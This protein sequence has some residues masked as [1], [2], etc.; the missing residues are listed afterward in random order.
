M[1][2][3][4]QLQADEISLFAK[5]GAVCDVYDAITSNRPYKA[6]WEP[7][8]S[9]Q[10]M[11]QWEGHFDDTIFKAFVKSVGIYPIGSM[12][13]LKSGRLAVVIDQSQ[14]SLLMPLIKVFFS[15]KLNLRIKVEL[16]DLSNPFEQD[17]IVGHEDPI[18]WGIHDINEIWGQ[19]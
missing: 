3:P 14:K 6:G 9:M 5:M 11:A 15:T 18:S 2:Y 12:V 16:I 1:G 4:H 8:I 7:G 13:K 10:R 19:A 17:T